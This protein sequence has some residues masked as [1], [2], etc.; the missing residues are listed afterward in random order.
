MPSLFPLVPHYTETSP[1]LFTDNFL[2]NSDI[3]QNLWLCSLKNIRLSPPLHFKCICLNV[4]LYKDKAVIC[5]YTKHT[6]TYNTDA[7]SHVSKYIQISNYKSLHIVFHH[8]I[9]KYFHGLLYKFIVSS[10]GNVVISKKV[11]FSR[12]IRKRQK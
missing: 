8:S 2:S 10:T 12:L 5:I 4:F 3:V 6:D 11:Y 7:Y 1:W 9:H